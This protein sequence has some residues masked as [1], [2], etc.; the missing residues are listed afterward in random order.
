MR[1]ANLVITLRDG[2]G[3]ESQ[4]ILNIT[5]VNGTTDIAAQIGTAELMQSLVDSITTG[6]IVRCGLIFDLD[7]V[8]GLKSAP[9]ANSD[10]EEGAQFIWRSSTGHNTASRIPTFDEDKIVTATRSV[11]LSDGDVSDFNDAIIDGVEIASVLTEF[12]DSRGDDIEALLSAR[13]TFGRPR[14]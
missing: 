6:Q 3:L 2:K 11:D 5:S 8:G 13:E 12:L 4:I 9:N 14:L 7:L 10:I 1:P